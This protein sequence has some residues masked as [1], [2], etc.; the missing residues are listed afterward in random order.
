MGPENL[1]K[2]IAYFRERY[3]V[4]KNL[5]LSEIIKM[6]GG[7]LKGDPEITINSI[8][9]LNKYK[10][11]SIAP[12]WEKRFM[13]DVVPGMLLLTKPGWIPDK[14]FG[15]EVDDPRRA[16]ISLLEYFDPKT[17][18]SPTVDESAIISKHSKIGRNSHIGPNCIISDGALLGDDCVLVGNVW[19]G[20]HA[21]LGNNTRIEQGA[22]IHD[23][24]K[25]G[26]NCIIH[27]NAVIGSDG[28]GF[29]PDSEVGLLRIPQIGTVI[30]EDNVEIGTCTCID[31]ATFGETRI[32]QGTKIDALVKIGHNCHIGKFCIA[33]S[34]SGIAGS[35]TLGDGVVLAA[36]A[37]V[38]NHASVGSGAILAARAGVIGDI[39]E[40]K[41]VSGFPA[42]DHMDELRQVKSL[43]QLP[44]LFKEVKELKVI[45]NEIVQKNK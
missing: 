20:K 43:R 11:G 37:G 7:V 19:I 3:V 45:I 12:L 2:F 36:Q 42:Q 41:T 27:S 21:A 28:F 38:A 18:E 10:E 44:G 39:P 24:V 5:K 15:I 33:V 31:K 13:S 17:A 8:T 35:S 40:G 34:Q 25:I 9:A 29:I 26:N 23:F 16:L 22:V 1:R 6:I 32:S 30:I 14:C 4:Y